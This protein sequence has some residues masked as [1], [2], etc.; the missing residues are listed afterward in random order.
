M[1]DN[2]LKDSPT[3]RIPGK[4]QGNDEQHQS[5]IAEQ[6]Y[7]DEEDIDLPLPQQDTRPTQHIGRRESAERL[8]RRPSVYDTEY[9]PPLRRPRPTRPEQRDR[10]RE[11]QQNGQNK[12]KSMFV[13]FYIAILVLAVALCIIVA[14]FAIQWI[15][16]Q[17]PVI[18]PPGGNGDSSGYANGNTALLG[19]PEINNFVAM[20][21]EI[22]TNPRTLALQD[23]STS[24]WNVRIKPLPEDAAITNR[25]G[26]EITFSQLRVG[27]LVEIGYDSRTLEIVTVRES[28]HAREFVS[29]ENVHVNLDNQTIS[30]GHDVLHFNSQ[31]LVIHGGRQISI[32]EIS[33]HD[34]IT[35][36][37]VVTNGRLTAWMISLDA[38]H[39][40]L[41]LSNSDVI[42]NGTITIGNMHPLL[43][44]EINEPII[45]TEGAH[46]ILIQGNNIANFVDNIVINQG[47]TISLDLSNIELLMA[48]LNIVTTPENA[49]IFI[50]GERLMTPSPIAIPFGEHTIRVE[51]DDYLPQE[52]LIAV[53]DPISY[54]VFDLEAIVRTGTMRL[55][56]IPANAEIFANSIPV[57]RSAITQEFIA[58]THTITVRMP[59]F[60]DYTFLVTLAAGDEVTRT[61]VLS[62]SAPP[63]TEPGTT[64][65]LL[66]RPPP[67]TTP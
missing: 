9:N 15:R 54:A 66:D 8:V 21:T 59:G 61:V 14:I 47:Q 34:S 4:L 64:S 60:A 22:S 67:T 17:G 40:F 62:P 10:N 11:P 49:R 6:G 44:S 52:Q 56:T 26:G 27:Q 13:G 43:L 63:Q 65:S 46:R 50:D 37:A 7:L 19:R 53:I 55:Y 32:G 20:I 58:G 39:G 42:L 24:E 28:V 57:G 5:P 35:A 16:D 31:T 25:M 29:R 3:K 45:L 23:T 2:R 36:S 38:S 33:V 30:I 48:T 18:G 41:E 12:A 51:H 1:L